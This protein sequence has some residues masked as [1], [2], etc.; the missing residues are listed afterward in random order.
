MV[1]ASL[2]ATRRLRVEAVITKTLVAIGEGVAAARQVAERIVNER[3]IGDGI[4]RARLH[5]LQPPGRRIEGAVDGKRAVDQ[6]LL[7]EMPLGVDGI[8]LPVF[9][10]GGGVLQFLEMAE[11]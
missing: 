6:R 5:R 1:A 10:A 3:H 8:R 9:E 4:A 2:S 7:E 11:S